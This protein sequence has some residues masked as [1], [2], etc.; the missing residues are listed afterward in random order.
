MTVTFS[1]QVTLGAGAF[2]LALLGTGGGPVGLNVSAQVVSGR[3]VA[4]LTF[5]TNTD[6]GSNGSL[7]D[8]NYSL[9]I[10]AAAVT[11]GAGQQLDGDGNGTAGGDKVTSFFRLFGDA[12]GDRTINAADLNLFRSTFGATTGPGF[13]A[14]F[15]F[16]GD[17]VINSTDLNAFRLR[18]GA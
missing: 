10:H 15:D 8:G 12:N 9:T 13:L 5:L 7:A 2:D 16:N 1:G 3:T 18:F 6:P 17:G 11:D 4:T 14:Y